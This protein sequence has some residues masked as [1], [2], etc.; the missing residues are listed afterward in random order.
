MNNKLLLLT[1]NYG[2]AL[3]CFVC[4]TSDIVV[5]STYLQRSVMR[6]Q[7]VFHTSSDLTKTHYSSKL[8]MPAPSSFFYS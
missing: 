5:S 8:K 7:S 1:C 6:V 2:M 3:N 4:T